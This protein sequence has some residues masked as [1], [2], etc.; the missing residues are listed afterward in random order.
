MLSGTRKAKQVRPLRVLVADDSESV[1]RALCQML[2]SQPSMVVVCEA[3]DGLD[4]VR[5][6]KEYR[7]D[8]VLLDLAMPAMNGFVAARIIKED[9]PSTII[10]VVTQYDSSAFRREAMASGA[11]SFMVKSNAGRELVP[12]LR[13]IQDGLAA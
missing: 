3:V 10:I 6:A 2:E 5:K 7:P 9:L 13:S 12:Q 1:R 4:A 11:S 8:V